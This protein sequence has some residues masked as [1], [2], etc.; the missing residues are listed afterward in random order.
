MVQRTRPQAK[1]D[2]L[3]YPIRVRFIVP[4][5]GLGML[6]RNLDDWLREELG[7]RRYAKHSSSGIYVHAQQVA[8]YFRTVEDARRCVDA[9]PELELADGVA[10]ASYYSP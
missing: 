8:I 3:A 4:S 10:S 2:D 1:T 7:R 9:F 6:S 5:G